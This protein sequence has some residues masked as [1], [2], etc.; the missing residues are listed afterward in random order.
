M[1]MIAE[2]IDGERISG[3]YLVTSVSKGTNMSGSQYLNVELKDASGSINGKKWEIINGDEETFVAGNV[4]KVIADSLK[5]KENLQLKILSGELVPSN[6]IDANLFLKQPPVAKEELRKEFDAYVESIQNA[7]CKAILKAIIGKIGEQLYVHPAAVSI[8]HE[9]VAGLLMHS[10]TM[11][12]I[13]ETLIPIYAADRDILITGCLLHDIGKVIEIE[14]PV[15]FHY[16]L[17]GKLLGHISILSAMVKETADE[18]GITSEVPL[19]LQH[20]VLSHHG[21][22]D[23][24]SPVLPCTKEAM[25]LSLIDNMD[26]KM[27]ALN[28]ALDTVEPGE[29]SQK[30]FSLDGR[31]IY[32]PK[33]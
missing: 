14:G 21:Q 33:N 22:H 9:Y 18:L 13:A 7:D 26:C 16:S 15:V 6:E 29:F 11:C 32:K 4:V 23:Y 3:Q 17:E 25:L 20:M 5:Y 27:V 28:K 1:K 19:L 31:T 24:G 2:I 10:V 30:I 12:K 8:H